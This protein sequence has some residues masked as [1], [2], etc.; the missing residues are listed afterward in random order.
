MALNKAVEGWIYD[1]QRFS[2]HDG[3]GIRTTVFLKGCPL[4][5][6]WCHNPESQSSLLEIAEFKDRC[7]G[8]GQCIEICPEKAITGKEWFINRKICT[9]CGKCAEICPSGARKAI[10]EKMKVEDVLVEVRKDKIFYKNSGGGITLSG[11]EPL[12]Q[13]LF[14]QELLRRCKKED[15][16]TAI[17]TSGY[18]S[19]SNINK[20]LYFTDFIFYD[21]KHVDPLKHKEF[22]GRS[23]VLILRNLKKI[24]RRD[25]VIRVPLIRG[26]NDAIEHITIMAEFLKELK[27]IKRIEL[28]PYHRL[29]EAKYCRLCR[30]YEPTVSPPNDNQIIKIKE[31]LESYGF[32]VKS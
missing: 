5:C 24:V 4:K 9:R 26:F 19:W 17:E 22:T 8:C 15:I 30:K 20:V 21:I 23:N 2:L 32:E 27:Y 28:L 16:N 31:L 13:P 25:I 7:I 6:L 18:A 11:G 1:I 29:G 12:M 14:S 10:G 3:P